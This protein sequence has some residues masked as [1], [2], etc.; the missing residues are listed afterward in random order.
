MSG[1]MS[2]R[3]AIVTGAAGG[4][5][6]AVCERFL[7]EGAGVLVTDVDGEAA[8]ALVKQLAGAGLPGRAASRRLDV[9]APADW[10]R[11]VQLARR[12]FGYPD[13]LVNNAG[14]LAVGGV[15]AGTE[16]DWDRVVGVNQRGTWLGMRAVMPAMTFAGGGA[17]VN[18]ASVFALVGSG[19]AIAYHAA[20]GAIRAMTATA[21]VEYA[22][23]GVRV[24]AVCPGTVA[25]A[26]T[27][28]LPDELAGGLVAGTP[29]GRPAQP[30]E[31]A[32]AV[33]F[34]ASHE[35]SYITGTALAVDGG[36]TAR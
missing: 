23:R 33:L 12:R 32:A 2:G 11:A 36:Y 26:M 15:D 25:T 14:V 29:L 5:G 24:N 35:A 17:V 13:T 10:T 22:S 8:A 16:A 34:L 21:A 28:A 9:T 19:G 3:I 4:I 18:V 6:R 30:E 1:R 20:K 7:A 27:D 31:V